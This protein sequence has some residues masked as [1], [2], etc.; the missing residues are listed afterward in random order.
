MEEYRTAFAALRAALAAYDPGD[1]ATR[2]EIAA[3]LARAGEL[4][5]TR[6]LRTRAECRATGSLRPGRRYLE[7][8]DAER[9]R[10]AADILGCEPPLLR[11]DGS[12]G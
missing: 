10:L 6:M 11:N 5:R 1:E 8:A 9:V 2:S 3:A 7:G 4:I 12:Q